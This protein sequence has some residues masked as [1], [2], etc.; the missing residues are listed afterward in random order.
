MS[1][2]LSSSDSSVKAT[3]R[4]ARERD[5]I[6]VVTALVRELHPQRSRFIDVGP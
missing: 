2:T 4:A 3:G 6:M 1:E 5:L